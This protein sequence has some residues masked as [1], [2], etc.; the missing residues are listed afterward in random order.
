[1]AYIP[2]KARDAIDVSPVG[3]CRLLTAK[4]LS[5]ACIKLIH[6]YAGTDEHK[7]NEALGTLESVKGELFRKHI[8]PAS[9]Q[10]EFD[11]NE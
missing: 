11:L 6:Q 1:M 4:E 3:Q 7:L 9:A 5:Y 8:N 2:K 10:H